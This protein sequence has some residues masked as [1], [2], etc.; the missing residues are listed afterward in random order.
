MHLC[1]K[2]TPTPYHFLHG[3]NANFEYIYVPQGTIASKI[4]VTPKVDRLS[5]KQ[6]LTAAPC[7][8]I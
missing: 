3:P 8:E 6:Q 7:N 4:S 1:F 5:E 2:F